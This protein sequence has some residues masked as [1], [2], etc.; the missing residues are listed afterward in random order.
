VA[1]DLAH[2]TRLL[3]DAVASGKAAARSV[4]QYITGRHLLTN[5]LTMHTVV[6]RYEREHGY[7][8]L[9]RTPIP[10]APP[11]R[12]LMDPKAVVETGYSPAEAVRE[13]S[14]CLDCSVSPVF[15]GSRCVLCG[16]CS[17]VCP[18]QCLKLVGLEQ[19]KTDPAL[20]SLMQ[21]L[22]GPNANPA[23]NSAIL[24]DE[25][26]C[27]RCALCAKRCPAEAITMERISY[28]VQWRSV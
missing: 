1:G 10:I 18:T 9:R 20:E 25:D 4:Y 22:C 17:D 23:E 21:T 7:E 6:D 16:G 11:D 12:R 24:K 26:R 28:T 8:T 5:A 3:I 19:L 27:I 2:G 13:A 15:D 14:R